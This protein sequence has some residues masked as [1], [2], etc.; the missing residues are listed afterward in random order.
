MTNEAKNTTFTGL[1]DL[2]QKIQERTDRNSDRDKATWFSTLLK[3]SHTG[4]LKIR[5]MQ[6]L[7]DEAE[8]YREDWGLYLGATEHNAPGPQGFQARALDT[9][10]LEGRDW[11]Q[12]QHIENPRLGWGKKQNFYITVAVESFD[13]G[14]GEKVVEPA[15][16]ARPIGHEF[17]GKLIQFNDESNGEGITGKTY[18]LTRTGQKTETKWN[19]EE[20]TDPDKQIVFGDIAPYDLK[21]TA[22]I[23]VPYDKQQEF[24]MRKADLEYAQRQADARAAKKNGNDGGGSNFGQTNNSN[25]NEGNGDAQAA[26]GKKRYSW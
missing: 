23:H 15:I 3:N 19:I 9:F 1:G 12:E 6:E 11:A 8:L 22:V 18:W 17:V 2:R 20:E 21:E 10:E 25:S 16:L 26:G 14:T 13:I 7:T 4:K 5:F 24:Y